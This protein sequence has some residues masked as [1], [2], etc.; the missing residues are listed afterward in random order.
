MDIHQ[1]SEAECY[2]CSTLV[3]FRLPIDLFSVFRDLFTEKCI[4][5]GFNII[6]Q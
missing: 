6:I 5:N 2:K 3:F 4:A 1:E